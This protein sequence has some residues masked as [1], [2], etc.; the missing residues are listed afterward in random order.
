MLHSSL[1]LDKRRRAGE[2]SG[3]A[4]PT[5]NAPTLR[6][7]ATRPANTKSFSTSQRCSYATRRPR[8]GRTWT[9]GL[10]SCCRTFTMGTYSSGGAGWILLDISITALTSPV[11]FS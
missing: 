5:H 3:A 6:P 1:S 2:E 8:S 9:A 7:R 11:T 10:R 4:R